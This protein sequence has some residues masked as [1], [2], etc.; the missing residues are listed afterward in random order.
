MNIVYT[1]SFLRQFKKLHYALQDEAKQKISLFRENPSE[2]SLKSHKLK[3]H[4]KGYCSF[5][6]NYKYRIIYEYD[7]KTT[8]ALLSI[9]DHDIYN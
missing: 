1:S 8:V 7:S 2:Q 9:G 5:S 4:L 3:G 6:V